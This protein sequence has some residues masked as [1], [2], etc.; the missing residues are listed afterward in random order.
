MS[1]RYPSISRDLN[2]LG[3]PWLKA[4]IL[5]EK[6]HHHLGT[7]GFNLFKLK[8]ESNFYK[9]HENVLNMHQFCNNTN[10][11]VIDGLTGIFCLFAFDHPLMRLLQIQE[12]TNI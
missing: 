4:E 10:M 9:K 2:R 3:T 8:S 1:E 12:Y 7:G 11:L 6:I 5:L